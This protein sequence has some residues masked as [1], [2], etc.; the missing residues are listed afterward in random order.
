MGSD[1]VRQNRA[2]HKAKPA[3]PT[4]SEE[5]E[6]PNNKKTTQNCGAWTVRLGGVEGKAKA[7][8]VKGAKSDAIQ[9]SK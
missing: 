7:T 4:P 8:P 3:Y 6:S 5:E 2:H 1:P 9:D